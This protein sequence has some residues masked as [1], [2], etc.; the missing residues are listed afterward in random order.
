MRESDLGTQT[1]KFLLIT[2]LMKIYFV[3]FAS[4]LAFIMEC[5]SYIYIRFLITANV[6]E[7]SY[8]ECGK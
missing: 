4:A 5:I 8:P 1:A 7:S 6:A 3:P 2:F